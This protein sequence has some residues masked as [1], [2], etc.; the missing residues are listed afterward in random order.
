M[1]LT[2]FMLLDEVVESDSESD[3]E[4][5]MSIFDGFPGAHSIF[6]DLLQIIRLSES[7]QQ[8]DRTYLGRAMGQFY[9][10]AQKV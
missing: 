2:L 3:E 4:I 10:Y 9:R 8:V 6:E 5:D 7:E 1:D